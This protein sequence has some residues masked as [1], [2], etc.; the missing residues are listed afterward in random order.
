MSHLLTSMPGRQTPLAR[1]IFRLGQ[2]QHSVCG[3]RGQ[4]FCC[5]KPPR[6][7]RGPNRWRRR[8][9]PSGG[10]FHTS[11]KVWTIRHPV[12]D[13]YK[14]RVTG[15]V[16]AQSL[17]SLTNGTDGLGRHQ[18]IPVRISRAVGAG[19]IG[20]NSSRFRPRGT[21]RSW[22]YELGSSKMTLSCEH[23][24]RNH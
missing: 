23:R 5:G 24:W 11:A 14:L 3:Q 8:D 13:R 18:R 21:I 2:A 1:A 4:R 10:G 19:R 6:R 12:S 16:C 20:L 15:P 9:Q 7:A 22:P 17:G